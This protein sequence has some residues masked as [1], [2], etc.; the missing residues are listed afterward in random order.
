[1]FYV[2][3]STLN[4]TIPILMVKNKGLVDLINFI[5]VKKRLIINSQARN[6]IQ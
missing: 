5:L 2:I 4:G 1:M 3:H 6:Q